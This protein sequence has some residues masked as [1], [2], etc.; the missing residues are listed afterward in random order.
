MFVN[1]D[2]RSYYVV[3]G[4]TESGLNRALFSRADLAGSHALSLA[5]DFTAHIDMR[6]SNIRSLGP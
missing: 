3:V 2:E 5:G 1:I 4:I 6:A